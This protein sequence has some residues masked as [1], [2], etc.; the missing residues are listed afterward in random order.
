LQKGG[1]YV[2]FDKY[3]QF[4]PLDHPLRRDIKNFTKGVAVTSL[5]PPTNLCAL[6][7]ILLDHIDRDLNERRRTHHACNSELAM[8]SLIITPQSR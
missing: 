4:L 7:H 3:Q 2:A 8:K 5:A 6:N 1:K